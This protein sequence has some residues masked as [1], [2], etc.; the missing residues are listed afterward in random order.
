MSERDELAI[1][2][3]VRA[4]SHFPGPCHY[5]TTTAQGKLVL[6]GTSL[7]YRENHLNGRLMYG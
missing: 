1:D 7:E 4:A 2:A 3:V 5:V 6:F